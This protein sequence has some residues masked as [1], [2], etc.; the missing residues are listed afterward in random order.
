MVTK[1]PFSSLPD[2]NIQFEE[3]C[4]CDLAISGE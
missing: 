1:I 4:R 2:G 3:K